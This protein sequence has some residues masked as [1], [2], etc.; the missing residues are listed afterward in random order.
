[1]EVSY[2]WRLAMKVFK[3]VKS[4]N[5]DFNAHVFQE[6]FTLCLEKKCLSH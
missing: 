1:M 4:L 5:P 2:L 3:A 6:M